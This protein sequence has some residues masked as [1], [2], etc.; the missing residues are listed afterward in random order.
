MR[1]ASPE[2]MVVMNAVP[3]K[4]KGES[5]A[6]KTVAGKSPDIATASVPD[7]LIALQVNLDTGL[8]GAEVDT[9]A[10]SMATMK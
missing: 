8:T 5:P 6:L 7:T 2:R 10:R 3:K 9:A 4:S 1:P